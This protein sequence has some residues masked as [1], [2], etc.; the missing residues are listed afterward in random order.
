[1][2]A[3]TPER[4]QALVQG[5]GCPFCG[6]RPDENEFWS[7]VSTLSVSTLYLH[8]FQTYRGYAVLVFDPRHATRPGE[9]DAAEWDAFS[10]DLH[11][12]QTAVERVTRPTHMN[13]ASLGN[14][15]PHLHWHIIPRYEDDLRWGGPIWTTTEAEME[16][17]HLPDEAHQRL[18]SAIR[19]ECMALTR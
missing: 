4:W 7:K 17:R 15:I 9:L 5:E 19:A 12:A 16:I 8:K 10:T 1:M 18:V 13:L 2:F 14:Q 6:Q 11:R 3:M